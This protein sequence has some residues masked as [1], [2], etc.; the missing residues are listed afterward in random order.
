MELYLIRAMN[1]YT[2]GSR[3]FE[4]HLTE[5]SYYSRCF[6]FYHNIFRF[7]ILTRRVRKSK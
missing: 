5:V 4:A 3:L 2:V 1:K 6:E 7:E